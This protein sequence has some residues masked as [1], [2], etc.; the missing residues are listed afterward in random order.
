MTNTKVKI[1]GL[2]KHF[3]TN[4]GL[5]EKL[6]GGQDYVKAVDGIDLSIRE[7]ESFGLAG[8]SGCG[9]TTLGKTTLLLEEPTEGSIYFDE[10][11]ITEI[12]KSK[13]NEFRQDAQIVHQDPYE[14]LNPRFTVFDWLVEPLEVH[15]IGNQEQRAFKVWDILER[16]NL[17]PHEHLDLY[18]NELSGGERQRVA[19]A[20]A[21]VT[22]P[23]FLVADEPASMLDVSLRAQILDLFRGLQSDLGLT[24]LYISHDLSLLRYMC[25]RIGIMYL[26]QIVEVGPTEEVINNP[27][28]PYTEALVSSVPEINPEHQVDPIR[29]EGDVPDPVDVPSH[30]RFYERCPKAMEECQKDEPSMY[31]ISDDHESKCFLSRD[32]T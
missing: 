23:S 30:C 3:R 25:D 13:L 11:D 21:L 14:S 20:R 28:H 18:T 6:S 16:V 24:A 27:Q 4:T 29:L 31:E 32:I 8:E 22:D 19:I 2:K 10:E 15:D 26:G 12:E 1:E 7:G 17:N 5:I 9:K